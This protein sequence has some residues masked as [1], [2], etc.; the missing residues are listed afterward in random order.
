[1]ARAKQN[2]EEVIV[3]EN[4]NQVETKEGTILNTTGFTPD[5]NIPDVEIIVDEEVIENK[6]EEF[7]NYSITPNRNHRC[8]IGG[9][10]YTLEKGVPITVPGYVKD[11]LK[12]AKLLAPQ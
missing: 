11:V 6:A 1:M 4:L 7:K 3:V 8:C 9:T 2:Q 12:E 10:W 5:P